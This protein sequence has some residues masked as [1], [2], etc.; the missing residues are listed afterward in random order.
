MIVQ[1][2]Q[3]LYAESKRL[4]HMAVME[5]NLERLL[6]AGL[7]ILGPSPVSSTLDNQWP[8]IAR[9]AELALPATSGLSKLLPE[10]CRSVPQT[11]SAYCF[12]ILNART[13]SH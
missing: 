7:G 5:K 2:D 11:R 6:L 10:S 13:L 9:M 8:P 1:A 12:V 4:S 3:A